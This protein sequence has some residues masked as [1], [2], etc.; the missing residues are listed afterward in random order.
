MKPIEPEE[1]K[2][3]Q[4]NIL[5][6]VTSFCEKHNIRYF[7]AYGTLLGA[8]RHKGYIPWDDDIDIHIPRPDYERFVEL[9]NKENKEY[10]V[11]THELNPKY[12]V[13]FAKVHH[14][15]TVL[16]EFLY[17]N[18]GTF[19]VYIDLFPLDGLKSSIQATL[20]GQCIRFMYVKSSIFFKGQT[21]ARKLRLAITKTILLPFSRHFILSS[22]RRIATKHKYEEC[23]RVCSFGS[24]TAAREILPSNIFDEYIMQPFEGRM[25]RIPKNY[26]AYL[27]AKY[28]NYMQLPPVELRVST[29]DSQAYWRD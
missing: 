13:P 6:D 17:K 7:L 25:Y 1:L 15:G 21:L 20:C 5:D 27:T 14:K 8:V 9:Y 3:I 23:D 18:P 26:D 16:H 29:H 24:R 2:N 19:G 22:M 28:G 11:I 4:L 12:N 10:E